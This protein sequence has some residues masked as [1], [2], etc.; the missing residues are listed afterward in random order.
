MFSFFCEISD[1]VSEYINCR[2]GIVL[3]NEWLVG[4]KICKVCLEI[5]PLHSIWER[6]APLL[7]ILIF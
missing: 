4:K 5:Q 3:D 1:V 7:S 2:L 6:S